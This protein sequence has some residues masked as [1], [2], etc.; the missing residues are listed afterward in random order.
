MLGCQTVCKGHYG[1][2][3]RPGASGVDSVASCPMRVIRHHYF[4]MG[5][6]SPM[7]A[8]VPRASRHRRSLACAGE[9]RA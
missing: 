9:G 8:L 5:E 2:F 6:L 4:Q 3:E 1:W 7:A